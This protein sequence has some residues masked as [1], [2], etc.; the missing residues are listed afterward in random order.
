MSN[1]KR[2]I[3]KYSGL[4]P[5]VLTAAIPVSVFAQFMPADRPNTNMIAQSNIS[6]VGAFY[7]VVCAVTQWVLV[8]GLIIGALFVIYGGYKYVTSAGDDSAA[9]DA[10]SIITNALIGVAL[11]ILA[12]ALIRIVANFFGGGAGSF[13]LDIM[14]CSAA[15]AGAASGGGGGGFVPTPTPTPAGGG[16]LAF[17]SPPPAPSF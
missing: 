16:G 3:C 13:Q 1:I 10:R 14:N 5:L 15:V 8:F 4:W 2:F 6:S 12:I 9:S 11:L 17:P 7:A